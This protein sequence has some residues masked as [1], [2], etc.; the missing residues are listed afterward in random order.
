MWRRGERMEHEMEGI[1]RLWNISVEEG[2]EIVYGQGRGKR[3]LVRWG[4][5]SEGGTCMVG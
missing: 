3:V 5:G 4:L 1:K 2:R